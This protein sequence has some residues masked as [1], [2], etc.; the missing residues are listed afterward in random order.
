MKIVLTGN[1]NVGKTSLFNKITRSSLHVGNWHGVSVEIKHKRI[2]KGVDTLDVVDLPGLYA[3]SALGE[4]EQ[5][6]IDYI[7]SSYDA[8]FVNILD[9]NM[10]GRN[11]YFLLQLLEAGLNVSL[12]INFAKEAGKRGTIIDKTKLM[13]VLGVRVVD[14]PLDIKQ[15]KSEYLLPYLSDRTIKQLRAIIEL[16]AN[17]SGLNPNFCAIKLIECDETIKSRLHLSPEQTRQ[18][19]RILD[20]VDIGYIARLRYEYIDKVV[21]QCVIKS[22]K[23]VG[24][25]KIDKIILNKYLALPIFILILGVIFFITFSYPG[26]ACSRFIKSSINKFLGIPINAWLVDHEAPLWVIDMVSSGIMS[27]VGGL[28]SFLPQIVLLFL[29][30]T[31]LEDSGYLSRL[32]FSLEDIFKK[33]GLSGKSVF[34][35]LMGF[36]CATSAVITSRNLEDKNSKIKTAMITPYMSC[37]AK[38]PLYAILGGC[39]FGVG[40]IFV[41]MGLYLLGVIVALLLSVILEKTMLKSKTDSFMLEFPPYRMIRFRRVLGAI[42]QNSKIFIIRIGSFLLALN[43]IVWLLQSFS[44]SFE[45]I[46]GTTH[47]SMLQTIGEIVAPLLAPIGL[48]NWGIAVSLLVGIVAK[49]MVVSS[50][51]IINNVPSSVNFNAMVGATILS[52]ASVIHFDPLTAVVCMIFVL[53]YC[54]CL[55]TFSVMKREIG[56]N[57]AAFSALLQL[58]VAYSICLVVYNVGR[59]FINFGGVMIFGVLGAIVVALS[60]WFVIKKIVSKK[61]C[62]YCKNCDRCNVKRSK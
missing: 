37:S 9:A 60:I 15:G 11:L 4:D 40:N 32:A 35:L 28:L 10:L 56:F 61:T 26:Q 54:P 6:P 38:L 52:S 3:L 58:A 48:N 17:N 16:N 55:S 5:V 59:L 44:F 36:G 1:P 39:F 22:K 62:G 2:K 21:S 51:A 25:Y 50:I 18:I 29:F 20:D 13:S 49:E 7:L 34:T 31:I 47:K 42:W 33:V 19:D 43:I 45:Y 30:L 41:V 27:G 57:M 53:L 46:V 8:H 24:K 12:Y 23:C 14:N